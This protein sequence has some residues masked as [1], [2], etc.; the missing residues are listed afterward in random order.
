MFYYLT[1]WHF[2]PRLSLDDK[3]YKR[4]LEVAL[5][6]SVKDKSANPQ[7]VQNSKEQ[8]YF[9][10]PCDTFYL[11]QVKISE[12]EHDNLFYTEINWKSYFKMSGQDSF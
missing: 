12:F 2:P 10:V 4:D 1:C 11:Y 9:T 3:L 6:L 7:E 5:A 8:G